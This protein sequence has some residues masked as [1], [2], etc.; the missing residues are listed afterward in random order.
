MIVMMPTT[1]TDSTAM[2][3]NDAVRHLLDDLRDAGISDLLSAT[4][5]VG[6][7]IADLFRAAGLP[8]PIGLACWSG[9]TTDA[10]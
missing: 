8:F 1:P 10:A 4:I 9:D 7:L 6:A 3:L 5:S 2:V